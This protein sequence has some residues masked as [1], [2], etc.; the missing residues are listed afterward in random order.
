MSARP[1]WEVK[2]SSAGPLILNFRF[3]FSRRRRGRGEAEASSENWTIECERIRIVISYYSII[4]NNVTKSYRA[5]FYL[6]ECCQIIQQQ[7]VTKFRDL[8]IFLSIKKKVWHFT[9]ILGILDFGIFFYP[10]L[11]SSH[12]IKVDV[13]SNYNKILHYATLNPKYLYLAT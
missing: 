13:G 10:T 11:C 9:Y 2:F 5:D 8:K 1:E 3:N 12:N 6:F 7:F 4:V